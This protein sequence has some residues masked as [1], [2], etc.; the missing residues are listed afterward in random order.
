MSALM[1]VKR[2]P[3]AGS[4]IGGINPADFPALRGYWKCNDGGSTVHDYSQYGN[5]LTLELSGAG[6][7][8]ATVWS[9]KPGWM[10]VKNHDRARIALTDSLTIG[11]K[12]IVLSCEIENENVLSDCDM[13]TAWNSNGMATGEY[14][15]F[16]V[17]TL[18]TVS[19]FR[20][21]EYSLGGGAVGHP[22][23][24]FT[25]DALTNDNPTGIDSGYGLAG[26]FRPGVSISTSM[27]GAELTTSAAAPAT[28][29]AQESTF[30]LASARNAG[31]EEL[32]GYTAVRNYQL[33]A[34][35][36]EPPRLDY[37][38][39]WMS[40]YPGLLPPWWNGI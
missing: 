12:F 31:F 13:G 20:T 8:A 33:W 14:R 23:L 15:G 5:H 36:S 34:F 40:R 39:R 21:S 22:D 28:L 24:I 7:T 4:E 10:C 17:S 27:A 6:F 37:T 25:D 38:L 16:S 1:K 3:P 35:D 18:G 19:G 2:H 9:T 29:E 11:D 32:T 26:A 30:A